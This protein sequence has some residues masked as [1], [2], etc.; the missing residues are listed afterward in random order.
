MS[1]NVQRIKNKTGI[2][3]PGLQLFGFETKV[4]YEEKFFDPG[5]IREI[6]RTGKTLYKKQ[7]PL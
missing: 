4:F 2:L 6:K 3:E 7:R 5:F 1:E